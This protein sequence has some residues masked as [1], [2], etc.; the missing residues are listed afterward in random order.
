[1]VIATGHN[2][3]VLVRD[4]RLRATGRS[5]YSCYVARVRGCKEVDALLCHALP[6]ALI[7]QLHDA[8]D[9]V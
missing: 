7:L 8:P 4:L 9:L 6:L 5:L 1:M 2:L 3:V